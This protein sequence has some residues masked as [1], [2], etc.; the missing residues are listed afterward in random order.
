MKN[1][2]LFTRSIILIFV[3]LFFAL[4][5]GENNSD[6]DA[7]I[8]NNIAKLNALKDSIK[9]E[10][11]LQE[12]KASIDNIIA[13]VAEIKDSINFLEKNMLEVDDSLNSYTAILTE[14]NIKIDDIQKKKKYV[15]ETNDKNKNKVTTNIA[16]LEAFINSLKIS[17]SNKEGELLLI[18]KRKD[19]ITKKNDALE[20][21][22]DYKQTE[23]KELY[24][25]QNAQL[26]IKEVNESI[27]KI[28]SDLANNNNLL[29]EEELNQKLLKNK[30]AALDTEIKANQGQFKIEY[31][32]STGMD[33]YVKEEGKALDNQIKKLEI[34]ES[35]NSDK[36]KNF[37]EEKERIEANIER[38]KI[39]IS[40]ISLNSDQVNKQENNN[41]E[42]TNLQS[43]SKEEL[44]NSSVKNNENSKPVN[45]ETELV[46]QEESSSSFI[47]WLIIFIVIVVSILYWLGKKN[48]NK[49]SN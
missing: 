5:C 12:S 29:L 41:V 24:S 26:K 44:N 10:Q 31:E 32:K 28:S 9:T 35:V 40:E 19:L 34:L 33:D 3:V 43:Q 20:T 4:S 7:L 11:L 49:N 48:K 1:N 30:I 14:I 23:L 2:D 22:L 36:W 25:Q 17:K 37:K 16:D 46:E 15:S 38:L 8:N 27:V 21:E 13:N 39:E 42:N 45:L 47:Y 6:K 18:D